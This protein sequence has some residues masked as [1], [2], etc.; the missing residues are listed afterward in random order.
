MF[1][2]FEG[3]DG[4]GKTAQIHLLQARL[5]ARAPSLVVLHEPGGT[6][7]GD[8]IDR[9][10]KHLPE[11]SLTAEAELLLFL[12]SRTQ[13]VQGV[14]R[15][16]L[17]DKK[18]V[19][20]DR[21]ASSTVAYQGFGRGLDLKVVQQLL[22]FS[23]GGLTPDITILL[24]VPVRVG[25]K[26]KAAEG[27][28]RTDAFQ[29]SMFEPAAYDRFHDEEA[30]FH[31]RVGEGYLKLAAAA[32]SNPAAGRW[33]IIDGTPDPEAVSERIWATIEPIL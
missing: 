29:L 33:V 22:D 13:L 1:I 12:A 16:A 4:A 20:C 3:I 18:I 8:E 21:F 31:E 24:N 27:V 30:E 14:I 7:L 11:I 15:P 23:T 19:L 25:L 2:V 17:L 28:V 6:A 32:Q 10:V 5:A 9:L 26:R